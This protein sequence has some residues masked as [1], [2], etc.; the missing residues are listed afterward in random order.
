MHGLR[1]NDFGHFLSWTDRLHDRRLPTLQFELVQFDEKVSHNFIVLAV[2][3]QST[4]LVE[5]VLLVA[6]NASLT[7]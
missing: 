4:L 7:V 1:L 3:V 6:E 2:D 5:V